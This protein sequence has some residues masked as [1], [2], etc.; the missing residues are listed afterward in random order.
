MAIRVAN[1]CHPLVI[2]TKR[3]GWVR[4]RGMSDKRFGNNGNERIKTQ[5]KQKAR[6]L[7]AE[8]RLSIQ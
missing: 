2:Q 5:S 1:V 7:T 8:K 4:N 6:Q 3:K